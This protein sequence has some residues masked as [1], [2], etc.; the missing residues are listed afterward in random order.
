MSFK[1][2][3]SNDTGF[4]TDKNI[5]INQQHLMMLSYIHHF[6]SKHY[7]AVWSINIHSHILEYKPAGLKYTLNNIYKPSWRCLIQFFQVQENS[8][9]HSIKK[10]SKP[11]TLSQKNTQNSLKYPKMDQRVDILHQF[12]NNQIPSPQV[13]DNFN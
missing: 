3:T 13:I 6:S 10:F 1:S 9:G 8:P 12:T 2:E 11:L 5:Y 7:Y 4:V